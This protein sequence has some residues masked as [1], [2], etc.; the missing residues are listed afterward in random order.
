MKN[1]RNLQMWSKAHIL[2]LAAYKNSISFPRT[3]TFGLS[4]QIRRW[5]ASIP[6]N[7]AEGCGKRSNTEFQRF[8][9]IAT[10]SASE[11]ESHFCWPAI[12]R[13]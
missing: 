6:A 13:I 8:L 7:I 2:I 9:S 1:F 10:G 11:L 5:A 3:E 12:S 4:S